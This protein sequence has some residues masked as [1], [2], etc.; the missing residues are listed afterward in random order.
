MASDAMAMAAS[1][2]PESKGKEHGVSC[3]KSNPG[4]IHETKQ[5]SSQ[6]LQG[7]HSGGCTQW[8]PLLE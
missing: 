6:Q 5:L 4:R 2:C 7:A 8:G 3:L 1:L